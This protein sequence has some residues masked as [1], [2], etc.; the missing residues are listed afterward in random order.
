MIT[1]NLKM[2]LFYIPI[3]QIKLPFKYFLYIMKPL[4]ENS[5]SLL[6]T[7]SYPLLSY[8]HFILAVERFLTFQVCIWAKIQVL[9]NKNFLS[10][11]SWAE[12]HTRGRIL[13]MAPV[14]LAFVQV[15]VL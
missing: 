2:K 3:T 11:L 8:L 14:T 6:T 5:S 7:L 9:L 4:K 15:P 12:T 13:R 1:D 10:Y